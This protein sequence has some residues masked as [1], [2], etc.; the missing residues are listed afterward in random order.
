MGARTTTSSALALAIGVA[1]TAT[2]TAFAQGF[3][4]PEGLKVQKPSGVTQWASAVPPSMLL[5]S[6]VA[7]SDKSIEQVLKAN[8]IAYDERS[9]KMFTQLNPDLETDG[10][11]KAG[12]KFN[13]IGFD[14]ATLKTFKSQ[15]ALL[16]FDVADPSEAYGQYAETKTAR[17][18][19]LAAGYKVSAFPTQADQSSYLAAL[20]QVEEASKA[21][22]QNSSSLTGLEYGLAADRLDYANRKAEQIDRAIEASGSAPPEQLSIMK[23]LGALLAPVSKGQKLTR[24]VKITVM[25]EAGEHVKGLTVYALP[26]P[27]FDDPDAYDA[28]YIRDRLIRYSF[29]NETSP[30]ESDVDGTDARVWVG[31]KR[32]YDEMVALIRQKKLGDKYSTLNDKTLGKVGVEIKLTSPGD[33]VWLPKK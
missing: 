18:K 30:S 21:F 24:K 6:D 33:V 22:R 19:A 12:T 13:L 25:N 11:V 9:R 4:V 14:D 16:K 32:K 3:A 27:F 28:S 26:A 5:K 2:P 31:P 29:F 20:T 10:V 8:G 17:Y 7:T 23:Q 1:V 15:N